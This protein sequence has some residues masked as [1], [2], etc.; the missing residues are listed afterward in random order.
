MSLSFTEDLLLLVLDD[1]TG[2]LRPLPDR[3]L[4]FALAGAL[5]A[6]FA[7]EG[8]VDITNGHCRV[9]KIEAS[10]N[11]FHERMLKKLKTSGDAKLEN[12]LSALAGEAD[13]IQDEGLNRLVDRGILKKQ[14]ESFLWVFHKRRYPMVDN[15]E[16]EEVIRRIRKRV[17]DPDQTTRDRSDLILIALMDVCQL[18]HIVFTPTELEGYHNRIHEL[19]RREQIGKTMADI[20]QQI[21]Q[22]LLEIRTYSGL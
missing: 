9:T 13:A 14:D 1:S 6:E 15:K 3:A 12:W 16:E 10:D 21:Q 20:I 4:D 11:A 19:A 5:L 17:L 8:T 2:K 7:F 22:A 18:S